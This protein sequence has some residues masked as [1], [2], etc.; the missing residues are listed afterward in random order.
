LND[1]IRG[2]EPV[3]AAEPAAIAAW[4]M[5]AAAKPPAASLEPDLFTFH[6][7]QASSTRFGSLEV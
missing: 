6:L 7:P 3:S 4:R 1:T 2:A 5:A